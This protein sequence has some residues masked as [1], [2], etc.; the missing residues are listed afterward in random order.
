MSS[1]IL[2]IR[3]TPRRM[4]SATEA[5]EYCGLALKHFKLECSVVPVEMRG[6]IM[7]FDMRDLDAWIDSKKTGHA[8][9]D[10]EIIARLEA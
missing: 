10:E 5:A 1:A 2:N 7:R 6:N 9:D 4:L 8:N 3:V